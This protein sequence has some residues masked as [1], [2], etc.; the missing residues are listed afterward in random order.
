MITC[1]A[2][3]AFSCNFQKRK[4]IKQSECFDKIFVLCDRGFNENGDLC[5]YATDNET[6][7]I[8]A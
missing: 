7:A 5:D 6:I 4:K 1:D 2:R 8:E 3:F